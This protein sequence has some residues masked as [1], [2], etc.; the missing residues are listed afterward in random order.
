MTKRKSNEFP[1][2]GVYRAVPDLILSTKNEEQDA[3]LR[4]I[5][6][7]PVTI[8]T[9]PAGTGKTHLAVAYA[10]KSL[11]DGKFKQ[12]VV[13]RPAVEAGERLGFL[14][15]SASDKV[16]PYLEPIF[17]ILRRFMSNAEIERMAKEGTLSVKPLAFVR[18]QTFDECIVVADEMQNATPRQMH[19]MLT[20]LGRRGKMILT[21]DPFQT[22]LDYGRHGVDGLTDAIGRLQGLDPVGIVHLTVDAIVR[23][24]VVKLIEGRYRDG[25]RRGAQ[26]DLPTV[27]E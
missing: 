9:G 7:K 23:H 5:E 16:M 26:D 10:L 21:G 18:G 4:V 27:R 24:P 8:I 2:E 6:S 15:G 25:D 3:A 22:D 20:R 19:M 12:M 17:D 14:P 13:A 1:V 11:K